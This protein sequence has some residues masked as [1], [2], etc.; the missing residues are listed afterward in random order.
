MAFFLFC[1]LTFGNV[2]EIYP[3][4]KIT[5]ETKSLPKGFN[6]VD[7]VILSNNLKNLLEKNQVVGKSSKLIQDKLKGKSVYENLTIDDLFA[8]IPD[9]SQRIAGKDEKIISTI[10]RGQLF[11]L[12][13]TNEFPEPQV[14]NIRSCGSGFG[15]GGFVSSREDLITEYNADVSVESIWKQGMFH[16]KTTIPTDTKR[17]N[18]KGAFGIHCSGDEFFI[19]SPQYHYELAFMKAQPFRLLNVTHK[20]FWLDTY[21]YETISGA[22]VVAWKPNIQYADEAEQIIPIFITKLVPPYFKSETLTKKD[23]IEGKPHLS[24]RNKI[25]V[26]LIGIWLY[27]RKT[28]EIISKSAHESRPLTSSSSQ[29]LKYETTDV[30]LTKP[31]QI[32][33]KPQAKYTDVARQNNVQGIIRLRVTFN[34]NGT[35]GK[36]TPINNLPY[37]LTEQAVEAAQLIK[38]KP[39]VRNGVPFTVVKQ[40]EYPFTL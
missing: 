10:Y 17:Q 16:L 34:A 5:S 3:Q 25:Y 8:F 38:F 40:V 13:H 27:D 7:S 15:P 1:F 12:I 32:L 33:S 9:V 20:V 30:L 11:R 36:I 2:S 21:R 19:P 28:G 29:N 18:Y 24:I 22:G 14:I 39:A 23:L 37:G 6:G 35:I 4:I 31:L 26:D